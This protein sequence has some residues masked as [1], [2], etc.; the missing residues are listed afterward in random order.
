MG[1]E[2]ITE[3]ALRQAQGKSGV[4][5]TGHL[6]DGVLR[7]DGQSIAIEVELSLKGKRRLQK[8]FNHYL[9]A[10]EYKE[11][12]YFCGSDMIERHLKPFAAKADFFKLF[13]VDAFLSEHA[14]DLA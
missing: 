5:V 3:R 1:G 12:W 14:G 2:F 8:I 11:V 13:N 6:S 4:G 9:K 7:V 10:F